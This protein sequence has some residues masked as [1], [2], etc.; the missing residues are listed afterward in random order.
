MT[1]SVIT[2]LLLSLIPLFLILLRKLFAIQA[3]KLVLE[4]AWIIVQLAMM[5]SI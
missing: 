1:L 3:V 2:I 4:A 5:D